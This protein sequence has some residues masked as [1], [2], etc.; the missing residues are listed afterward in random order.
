ERAQEPRA[1]Y[2]AGAR[3]S[4]PDGGGFGN[5]GGPAPQQFVKEIA[6]KGVGGDASRSD[7]SYWGYGGRRLFDR[8]LIR[9]TK[10]TPPPGGVM[11]S[12]H[13][14]GVRCDSCGSF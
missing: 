9:P 6:P 12:S 11:K 7:S 13:F 8:I 14:M 10:T 5:R 2:S 4:S 1:K 3:H